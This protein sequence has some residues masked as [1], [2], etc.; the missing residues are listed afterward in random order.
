[1]LI[2]NHY[3]LNVEFPFNCTCNK[4]RQSTVRGQAVDGVAGVV[5][6]IGGCDPQGF[7][8]ALPAES[9]ALTDAL[10]QQ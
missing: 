7:S 5:P 10:P 9:C 6:P 8:F 4:H 3:V 2:L 1:M